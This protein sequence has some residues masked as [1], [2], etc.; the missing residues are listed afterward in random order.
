MGS[1]PHHSQGAPVER[2]ATWLSMACAVHCMLMPLLTALLPLAGASLSVLHH[3]ALELSFAALVLLGAAF[4]LLS[5]YRRHRD[6]GVLCGVLVGLVLYL[7]GH[8]SAAWYARPMSVSGALILAA[9]SFAS[10]RM[11]HVHGERCAH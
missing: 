8:L 10:A 9:A 4:T 2:A 6:V 3:P 1:S 7:F 11:A 5:G